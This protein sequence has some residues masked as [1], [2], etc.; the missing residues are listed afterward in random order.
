MRWS[1]TALRADRLAR[2]A[3]EPISEIGRMGQYGDREI[4][5]IYFIICTSVFIFHKYMAL[6]L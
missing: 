6:Q 5:S 2:G 4:L 3:G 1:R